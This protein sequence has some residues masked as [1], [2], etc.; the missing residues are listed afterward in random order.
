MPPKEKT[1]KSVMATFIAALGPM[2]FGYNMAYSSSALEDLG[3]DNADSNV[4]L[5]VKEGS[6]FSVSRLFLVFLYAYISR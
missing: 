6:W 5:T 3:N 1:W 4:H 2:S